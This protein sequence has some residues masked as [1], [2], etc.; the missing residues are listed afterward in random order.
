MTEAQPARFA[1]TAMRSLLH[2][3][4]VIVADPPPPAVP[5]RPRPSGTDGTAVR[6]LFPEMKCMPIWAWL[7]PLCSLTGRRG[8]CVLAA[9]S[10]PA[11]SARPSGA[12]LEDQRPAPAGPTALT[13]PCEPRRTLAAMFLA[14]E[15]TVA[16]GFA[17][18]TRRLTHV[19]NHGVIRAASTAAYEHGQT[20]VLRVGPAGDRPYLSKLV[21]AQF[22]PPVQRGGTLTL[23]LRWEAT[24]PAG[25]LFPALDAD[26]VLARD[27]ED[28]VRLGLTGSYRPPL[29]WDT[30][31]RMLLRRIATVTVRHL[32]RDLAGALIDPQP[33][34]QRHL[35]RAQPWPWTYPEQA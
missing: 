20:V 32:L 35:S 31:D 4:A 2:Q 12:S 9:R 10:R 16:V 30:L 28:Q 14:E 7:S 11:A 15:T 1:R 5:E 17:D 3:I 26:L 27:G 25:E 18:A 23:T 21:R 33:D 8:L 22:L 13:R 24:G 34:P 6:C 19:I 29:S